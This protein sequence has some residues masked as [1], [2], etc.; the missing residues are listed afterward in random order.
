LTTGDGT[1]WGGVIFSSVCTNNFPSIN[2]QCQ[3]C[4]CC[5]G[6]INSPGVFYFQMSYTRCAD[7]HSATA[8][9]QYQTLQ[10]CPSGGG[11]TARIP[12]TLS[13][14]A[15]GNW[16]FTGTM[17]DTFDCIAIFGFSAQDQTCKACCPAQNICPAATSVT[18]TVTGPICP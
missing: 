13:S 4:T 5:S 3:D 8:F 6:A 16:V 1:N 15:C 10:E 9:M 12:L 2:G 11:S 7:V 14:A 18:I 17:S